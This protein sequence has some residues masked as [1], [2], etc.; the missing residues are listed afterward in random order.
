MHGNETVKQRENST[1]LIR[2]SKIKQ[3]KKVCHD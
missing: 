2:S 1:K 3:L